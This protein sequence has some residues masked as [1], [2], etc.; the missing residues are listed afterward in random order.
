MTGLLVFL[1]GVLIFSETLDTMKRNM[2]GV[3][4]MIL[5]VL[6]YFSPYIVHVK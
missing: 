6:L 4:M 1:F 5:G 2:I 3:L